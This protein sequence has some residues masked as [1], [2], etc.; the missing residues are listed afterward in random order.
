MHLW[1]NVCLPNN[2]A[3][4]GL[5]QRGR[6]SLS[7]APGK[8]LPLGEQ[9]WSNRHWI[10]LPPSMPLS[11]TVASPQGPRTPEGGRSECPMYYA[12]MYI[13]I[14]NKK[15]HSFPLWP[16]GSRLT[17]CPGLFSSA[18]DPSLSAGAM[19]TG[20][21]KAR[22]ECEASTYLPT[23]FQSLGPCYS[24]LPLSPGPSS[25]LRMLPSP[26]SVSSSRSLWGETGGGSAP[27]PTVILRYPPRGLP[28]C[29]RHTR[30]RV[31][32]SDVLLRL[33]RFINAREVP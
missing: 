23:L 12:L 16:V 29:A 26:S 3:G 19:N 11:L 2:G 24:G 14:N 27:G 28:F 15:W 13:L 6:A 33:D 1:P 30:L 32:D 17:C 18:P 7:A 31:G 22:P 10:S 25:E 20:D 21:T 8:C 4:V 5:T 9:E